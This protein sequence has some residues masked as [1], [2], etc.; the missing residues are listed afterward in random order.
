MSIWSNICSEKER[1]PDG[2][3]DTDGGKTKVGAVVAAAAKAGAVVAAAAKVGAVVAAAVKVGAVVA[4]ADVPAAATVGVDEADV[5]GVGVTEVAA[6]DDAAVVADG[7]ASTSSAG[8]GEA[9]G[10]EVALGPGSGI[11]SPS[12]RRRGDQGR[13]EDGNGL[14]CSRYGGQ[15]HTLFM[16]REH[17]KIRAENRR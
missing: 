5:G 3:A 10:V 15:N 12:S 6:D 1:P 4:A 7:T 13:G 16:V 9:A 14:H 2:G 17:G 8:G 11:S